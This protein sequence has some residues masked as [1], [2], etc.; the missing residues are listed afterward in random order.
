MPFFREPKPLNYLQ[1]IFSA[2]SLNNPVTLRT[3]ICFP[4]FPFLQQYFFVF[5]TDNNRLFYD[6][7][8]A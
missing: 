2:K 8:F 7:N 1:K 5:K 3:F 6:K 4:L